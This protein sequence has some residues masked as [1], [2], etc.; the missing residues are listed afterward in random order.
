MSDEQLVFGPTLEGLFLK[1]LKGQ[2]SAELTATLRE[3]GLDLERPLRPAYPR[4][5]VNELILL[6]ARTLHP[7]LSESDAM[8]RIGKCVTPG[9][10]S[11]MMGAAALKIVSLIGPRRTLE[12]MARTFRGTNNYMSV[13]LSSTGP[14]AFT[15][16]LTPSN[17]YPSY[18]QAVIEDMLTLAGAASLKVQV[19]EHDVARE[20]CRYRISWG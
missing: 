14:T 1:G 2:L 16:E 15:L 9:Q 10:G 13:T 12:R 7:T 17:Q 5:L 4:A 11:T 19:V 18:M 20:H 8:Y 6:T 3:K